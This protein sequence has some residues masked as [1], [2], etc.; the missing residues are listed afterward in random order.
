M[1]FWRTVAVTGVL[2]LGLVEHS[3][4]RSV[5]AESQPA[6]V[7]KPESPVLVLVSNQRPQAVIVLA[8]DA[9]KTTSEA[10]TVLQKI[11][12][13]MTGVDLPIVSENEFQDGSVAILVGPSRLAEKMGV[14]VTQDRDSGDRYVI[15]TAK[16]RIALVGN[17]DGRRGSIFAVY[18]FL[19]R[20]GCGWF[21]HAPAWHVIP[22]RSTL[23]VEPMSVEE[24]PDF[25]H[26]EIWRLSDTLRDAWRLNTPGELMA[27]HSMYQWLPREEFEKENPDY[28]GPNQPC[29][30]HPEVIRIITDR[31]RKKID[32]S[33]EKTV[34]ISLSANDASSDMGFCEC[35]RC[36]K[37]GNA[38]SRT[39]YFANAIARELAKTHPNRYR[40]TFLGYWETHEAPNP[41]RKAEPGIVV[42]LVN[43]GDHV[44]PLDQPESPD[45][46]ASTG[47]NNTR[48][49][50][51]FAGWR[52]TGAVMAIYEWWIPASNN[53]VWSKIPWYSGETAMRNLRYWK[54]GEVRFVM[55]EAGGGLEEGD[56]F[57]LR[58]PLYYVG[59]RGTW[60]SELSAQQ[61]MR[62]ACDKLYG[63]AAEPMLR[64]YE[65]IERAMANSRLTGGNWNLPAPE[66]IYTPG[67]EA[68]ATRYLVEAAAVTKDEA[69]L[70]RIGQE[71]K[72]WEDATRLMAQL[73]AG[74]K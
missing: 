34:S 4:F 46:P 74:D 49:V 6:R 55:Y 61:I 17:D 7:E 12:R 24:S 14:K 48:E 60:D 22:K 45:I 54:Q 47:R 53:K 3:V 29:L 44:H 67:V 38:S 62:E 43:E 1:S 50:T 28:F 71:Q 69:I 68:Q 13:Q 42:M 73:R 21:G 23:T 33:P 18:D 35:D 51:A 37:T 57:P 39:L 32:S 31:I 27:Q 10:A 52:K 40:L 64:F 5:A 20:L 56:G 65:V 11:I 59:A 41:M 58:W 36:R 66:K 19:Q 26:R 2:V 70:T 72:M 8:A 15:Q 9:G 25:E 30:T 16:D 63:P